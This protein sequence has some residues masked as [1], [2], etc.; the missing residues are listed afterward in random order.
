MAVEVTLKDLLEAGVHFGHQTRKWNPKMR[1]YIFIARGGIHII[2]LQK[3]M[4]SLHPAYDFLTKVAA[5]G[6]QVLFVA[7]KKQARQPVREAAEAVEMPHVTER[8][9][10]GMLTNFQ[11]ISKSI[12]KLSEI[13]AKLAD[14]ASGT[15][16][17]KERLELSRL[18]DKLDRNLGG[19]REMKRLP[20]ALF[21]VDTKE[22]ETAV[23][24]ANKLGIPVVG[25]VDTNA[26]PDVIDYPI[27]G[28]D[29]AIRA[30]QLFTRLAR[31]A[32]AEGLSL[33]S[34]GAQVDDKK[35]GSAAEKKPASPVAARVPW[36]DLSKRRDGF[37]CP[38]HEGGDHKAHDG[39]AV[40]VPN[41]R[42][43]ATMSISAAQVKELRERTGAGMMD[44]K[45]ALT[46][47]SGDMDKA[48]EYLRT[49]GIAKA[50]KKADRET[51]QGL[52]EAYIHPG[53]GVGVLVEVQCETDFVARTDEFK[54]FVRDVAMHIA[55][56]NPLALDAEDL[57]M[58][59]LEKEKAIYLAQAKEEGK[60]DNIA[61]KIVEGR[62][63]KFRKEN[64]LL[65]Q[66]FVKNP[67]I[68]VGQLVQEKI[69]SLGENMKIAR[70]ARFQIGG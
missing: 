6:R 37:V 25:I 53:G 47:A 48:I 69:A 49:K 46:E 31:E 38:L 62:L 32:V 66:P 3:T 51:K 63:Q 41:P 43:T 28:N 42:G 45:K 21:V 12:T 36:P 50:A 61:E 5:S 57:D 44:C 4:R 67:D 7:T 70:F 34:E 15:L 9:L 19:I 13:E 18:R 52:V 58:S 24:E 59:T 29:D 60:P 10:G 27:P 35:K 1:E 20:G 65:E 68:T 56:S 39:A 22:E 54:S 8:W 26:D 17:K 64:A 30:I 33:G 55:A 23:K 11:T 14:E 2:D 16:S 40:S